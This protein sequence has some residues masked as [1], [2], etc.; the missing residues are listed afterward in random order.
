MAL[1]K[2]NDTAIGLE[3][4]GAG[5]PALIFVHGFAC[6]RHDWD[7]QLEALSPK[8]KVV[9][10]D[11][12]GH[13]ESALPIAPTIEALARSVVEIA[14]AYGRDGAVLIGHSMIVR[15]VFE[16]MLIPGSAPSLRQKVIPRA[17]SFDPEFGSKLLLDT[18]H[19]G[20][21]EAG[22]ALARVNIPLLALQSTDVDDTLRFHSLSPGAVTPWTELVLQSVP[23]AGLEIIPGVGH[24]PQIEA[25][26]AVS[27]SIAKFAGL[28]S[29]R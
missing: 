23:G 12:P 1:E 2:I 16:G 7:A 20:A 6:D 27:G 21:R 4:A 3:C 15:T 29:W 28:V 18:V 22:R 14:A 13:G 24:F 5:A 19:F 17:E 9:T 26:D 25:A 10:V 8:F 11:L